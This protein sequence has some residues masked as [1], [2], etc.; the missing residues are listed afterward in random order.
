MGE[1]KQVFS[2]FIEEERFNLHSY[3]TY[4]FIN[5]RQDNVVKQLEQE[6]VNQ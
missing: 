4:L 1:S 5:E 3:L 6:Y 2:T